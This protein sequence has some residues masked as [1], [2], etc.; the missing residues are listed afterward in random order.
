VEDY[1]DI[2]E[3]IIGVCAPCAFMNRF[4]SKWPNGTAVNTNMT[5]NGAGAKGSHG[6]SGGAPYV[7]Q[8]QIEN[9]YLKK[10]CATTLYMCVPERSIDKISAAFNKLN[11]GWSLGTSFLQHTITEDEKCDKT[12]PGDCDQ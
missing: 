7:Y 11:T 12:V 3:Y 6:P 9:S 8:P 10:R 1:T 2:R 4:T 5:T